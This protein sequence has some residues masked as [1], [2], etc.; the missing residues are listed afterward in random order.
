M[1]K[2]IAISTTEEK[3]L[4]VLLPKAFIK[5]T[6]LKLPLQVLQLLYIYARECLTVLIL[7][8]KRKNTSVNKIFFFAQFGEQGTAI[9][10]GL[11][12][13]IVDRVIA[14]PSAVGIFKKKIHSR[15]NI[16]T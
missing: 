4:V 2:G 13:S 14:A 10:R 8:P 15:S 16:W 11:E 12:G 1:Q 5:V 3:G 7:K 9:N 6:L